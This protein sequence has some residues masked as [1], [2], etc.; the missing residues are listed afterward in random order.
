MSPRTTEGGSFFENIH[1]VMYYIYPPRLKLPS[2]A[3]PPC[4]LIN[5]PHCEMLK[6]VQEKSWEW[7][8]I[9]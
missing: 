9:N 5:M 8:R 2:D 6:T 4:I 1:V 3:S 7:N